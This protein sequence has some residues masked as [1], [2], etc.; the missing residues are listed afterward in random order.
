M[1]GV[2]Q[3]RGLR[4]PPGPLFPDRAVRTPEPDLALQENLG[5]RP[6]SRALAG[7]L[8]PRERRLVLSPQEAVGDARVGWG[9]R[10]GRGARR[11]PPP[12]HRAPVIYSRKEGPP[13]LLSHSWAAVRTTP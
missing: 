3:H 2:A 11:A 12:G 9:Q 13:A 7:I 5:G 1:P 6:C 4:T 10:L 8:T